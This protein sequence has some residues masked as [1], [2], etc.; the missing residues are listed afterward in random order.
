MPAYIKMIKDIKG[1]HYRLTEEQMGVVRK[2]FNV[3]GIPYYILAG[4]DGK[5]AGRPDLRN[6]TVFTSAILNELN[7]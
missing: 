4:R 2:Q 3:D 7:K 5:A 1:I 6:H